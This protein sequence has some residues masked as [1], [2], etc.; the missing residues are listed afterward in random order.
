MKAIILASGIGSRLFPM[1]ENLPKSLMTVTDK[2]ILDIELENLTCC[3]IKKI[4]ITTGHRQ[5]KIAGHIRAN[6]SDIEI[7][8]VNNEKFDS[9]NYIYSI[10]LTRK[11]IDDDIV[12][13][14]GDL[15]FEKTLLDRLLEHPSENAALINNVIE[16]P[17]RDFKAVIQDGVIKKI[18]IEFFGEGA[19]F[20]APLY[21]FSKA[22]FLRWMA[23]IDSFVN[24]GSV[25]CYA[26]NAFNNISDEINLTPVYYDKEFCMEI[27]TAEDLDIA[28]KHY[29]RTQ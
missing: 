28:R 23:E 2:T 14:H 19:F 3:G 6:Y 21:K 11:L 13:L 4:I 29:E 17:K 5:E 1:T 12:I 10:W 20:C 22:G 16:L 9:T 7:S 15:V 26:E 27:D 18:G 8:L 25:T 24:E